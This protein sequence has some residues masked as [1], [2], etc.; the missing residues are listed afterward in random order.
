MNKGCQ[1][2]RMF[3]HDYAVPG[4]YEVT[5]AVAGRQPVSLHDAARISRPFPASL[6]HHHRRCAPSATRR[7]WGYTAYAMYT[8][9]DRNEDTGADRN[10]EIEEGA[11]LYKMRPLCF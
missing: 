6:V 3:G 10:E 8:E 1:T 9:A 11:S 5:I 4:T 7:T 2:R